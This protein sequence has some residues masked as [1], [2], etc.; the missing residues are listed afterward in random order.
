[1]P[2]LV[3]QPVLALV[4]VTVPLAACQTDAGTGFASGAAGGA[5]VGALVGGPVGA[6]VGGVAG[7]AY[8]QCLRDPDFRN[9]DRTL[10]SCRPRSWRGSTTSS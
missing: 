7:A 9:P 8:A 3:L 2:A 4:L 5:V 1:M 10:D 6:A